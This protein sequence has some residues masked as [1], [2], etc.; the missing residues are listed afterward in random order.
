MIR[1]SRHSLAALLAA[2]LATVVLAGCGGASA[3]PGATARPTPTPA[4]PSAS[5]N[6]SASGSAIAASPTPT[7]YVI[8]LPHADAKLEAKLPTELGGVPLQHYSVALSL[9]LAS[10]TGGDS[11]LYTPW[12]V[13]MGKT[14]QEVIMAV[15]T[16]AT[17]TVNVIIQAFAVP[18][19][20]DSKILSAYSEAA[21]SQG[22]KAS[23]KLVAQRSCV[24]V[25]DPN[26]TGTLSVGYAYAKGGVLY[27][28][29]TDDPAILI[30][31]FIHLP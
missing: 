16:D 11:V 28:V 26:P 27:V 10:T 9:Y 31:A 24:E 23:T 6:A 22:W 12:L 19:V 18:N 13:S 5:A 25:I 8:T 30:E 2:A 21:I 4:P 7:E 29:V 14:S 20:A 15:A 3:T 1:R 17:R